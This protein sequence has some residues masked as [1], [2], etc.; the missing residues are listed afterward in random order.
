[1]RER[2]GALGAAYRD[3]GRL[4]EARGAFYEA[5]QIHVTAHGEKHPITLLR[6]ANL[7]QVD[8]MPPGA[9]PTEDAGRQRGESVPGLVDQGRV[10]PV[11]GLL[12]TTRAGG[13]SSASVPRPCSG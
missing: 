6:L 12:I 9:A 13:A 3:A 10:Q 8:L 7:A 5:W 2:L 1:M 4:S 11:D